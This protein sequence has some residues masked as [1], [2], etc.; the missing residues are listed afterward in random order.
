MYACEQRHA[1]FTARIVS[2]DG[3][4]APQTNLFIEI[5]IN[6]LAEHPGI[7]SNQKHYTTRTII[8]I[9]ILRAATMCINHLR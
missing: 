8:T 9:R 2:V 5:L 4:F 6:R 1:T 7:E 3:V